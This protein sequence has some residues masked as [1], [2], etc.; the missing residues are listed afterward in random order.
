MRSSLRYLAAAASFLS[1]TTLSPSVTMRSAST[2]D[3]AVKAACVGDS[4]GAQTPLFA[5]SRG[6][7]GR[8]AGTR[9]RGLPRSCA[10]CAHGTRRSFQPYT[11]F[12]HTLLYHLLRP[13]DP[14]AGT[15]L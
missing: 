8:A 1:T 5:I 7:E 2:V 9:D 14:S 15:I 12:S 4:H 13:P 10:E 6:R 3:E 11:S